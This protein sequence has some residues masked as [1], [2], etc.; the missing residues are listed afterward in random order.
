MD[1]F[2]FF[3]VA[4]QA[5][6]NAKK[7]KLESSRSRAFRLCEGGNVK[8][9]QELIEKQEELGPGLSVKLSDRQ[10][11]GGKSGATLLHM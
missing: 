2:F 10:K 3:S 5:D 1:F 6:L 8:E 4:Y 9:F 11:E 7:G